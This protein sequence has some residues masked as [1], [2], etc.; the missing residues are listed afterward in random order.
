[1]GPLKPRVAQFPHSLRDSVINEHEKLLYS[2]IAL[3]DLNK[4]LLPKK[5]VSVGILK[6]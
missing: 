6:L 1:M 4:L 5:D 2:F 3:G